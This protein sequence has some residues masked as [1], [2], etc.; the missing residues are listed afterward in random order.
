[1]SGLKNIKLLVSVYKDKANSIGD[2]IIPVSSGAEKY[3]DKDYLPMKDNT[4][5][6]ISVKNDSYC[7][8][9]V[10]YWA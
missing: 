4:G 3:K 5:A 2:F 10:M 9:T 6:N 8:L 7:E 1:M